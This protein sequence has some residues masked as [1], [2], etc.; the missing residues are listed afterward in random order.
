M[1][2][3]ICEQLHEDKFHQSRK[4]NSLKFDNGLGSN[5]FLLGGL[6]NSNILIKITS[7]IIVINDQNVSRHERFLGTDDICMAYK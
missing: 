2:T 5:K 1:N 6:S 7:T 4:T 3:N